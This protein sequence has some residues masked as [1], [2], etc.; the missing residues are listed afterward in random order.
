MLLLPLLLEPEPEPLPEPEHASASVSLRAPR[1][2]PFPLYPSSIIDDSPPFTY[3]L[4]PSRHEAFEA[5]SYLDNALSLSASNQLFLHPF[6]PASSLETTCLPVILL[7]SP[8][9][10]V[11]P[12]R[13]KHLDDPNSLKASPPPIFYKHPPPPP[14][15]A[16]PRLCLTHPPSK[17]PSAVSISLSKACLRHGW[18]LQRRRHGLDRTLLPHLRHSNLP[19]G[20][21]L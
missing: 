2:G 21:L 19:R 10:R 3:R 7:E 9:W 16:P 20:L 1:L 14:V 4:S 8:P 18:P 15:T 6:H 5:S 13:Q 12:W 17:K 11:P